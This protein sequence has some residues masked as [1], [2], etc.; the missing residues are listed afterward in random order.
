MNLAYKSKSAK[1]FDKSILVRTWQNNKRILI[2]DDEPYNLMGLKII[3]AQ[4]EK[5]LLKEKYGDEIMQYH[6]PEELFDLVDQASNGK[7]AVDAVI[8]AQQSK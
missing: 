4:T 6:A 3:L 5:N 8:K 7:E 2:V 1:F